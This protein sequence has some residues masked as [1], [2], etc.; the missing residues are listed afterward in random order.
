MSATVFELPDESLSLYDIAEAA[1]ARGMHL[2]HNG[3]RVV[4]SPTIPPGWQK[5][6]VFVKPARGAERQVA[7]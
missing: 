7:A 1:K 4:V 6:G 3:R 5:L 2:I